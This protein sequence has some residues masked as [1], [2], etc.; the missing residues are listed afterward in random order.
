[1]APTAHETEML[2]SMRNDER[3]HAS[4]L[5]ELYKEL[6]GVSTDIS[7]NSNKTLL[8]PESY[9]TGISDALTRDSREIGVLRGIRDLFPVE[10][11]YRNILSRIIREELNHLRD[12]NRILA[13]TRPTQKL[14]LDDNDIEESA[15]NFELDNW[16]RFIQPLVNHASAES[17][18][19]VQSEYLY[20]KY[21]LA[22]VLVGL[23]NAPQDA[24]EIVE[25]WEEDGT[26]KLLALNKMSRYLL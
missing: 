12:L 16:I 8:I 9:L 10:S 26:S 22:G 20:R 6:T 19:N 23:G 18:A 15:T 1:M 2:Y 17:D 14:T 7:F 13:L 21:I 4:L 3:V 11:S 25:K 5:R 24:Y